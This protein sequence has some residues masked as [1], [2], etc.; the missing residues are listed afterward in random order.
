MPVTRRTVLEEL[1]A[2]SDAERQETTTVEALSSA[3]EADE[4]AVEAHLN[5]LEAC[6]LA[7]IDSDGRAR[8]T[9][10]GEE[11]LELDTD[12]MAVIDPTTPDAER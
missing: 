5:G 2:L 1:A 4:H 9:I 10:T 8:V 7:R 11:L 6:E 3:L 12:G